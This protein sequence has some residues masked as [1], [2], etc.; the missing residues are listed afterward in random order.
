MR[1]LVFHFVQSTEQRS[2]NNQADLLLLRRFSEV[3]R[4]RLPGLTHQRED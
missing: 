4:V 1:D 2:E 3:T